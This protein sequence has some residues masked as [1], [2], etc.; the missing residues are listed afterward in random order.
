MERVTL[1]GNEFELADLNAITFAQHQWLMPIAALIGVHNVWPDEKETDEQYGL[2]LQ[3]VVAVSGKSV[4]LLA[5]YLIPPG[6][7]WTREFAQETAAHLQS[8]TDLDEQL[9]LMKLAARVTPDF[10]ARALASF[11]ISLSYSSAVQ[12]TSD[13]P[14]NPAAV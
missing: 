2:R 4:E 8:I 5:G 3:R 14:D 9:T 13:R 12:R 11:G 10:F 6:G 1:G 7:R